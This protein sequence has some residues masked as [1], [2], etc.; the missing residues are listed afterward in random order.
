MV[1]PLSDSTSRSLTFF[2]ECVGVPQKVETN[3]SQI[4]STCHNCLLGNK[5]RCAAYARYVKIGSYFIPRDPSRPFRSRGRDGDFVPGWYPPLTG[6]RGCHC[7]NATR[8]AFA[9]L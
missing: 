6:S 9:S 8:F 2:H 3:Q 5:E 1:N 4:V 7:R